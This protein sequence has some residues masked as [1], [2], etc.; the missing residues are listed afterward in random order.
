MGLIYKIT[1]PDGKS[2]I[3]QT[4]MSF[5]QRI[6]YHK[7]PSSGCVY[8]SNAI[9]KHGDEMI[10][11]IIEEDIPRENLDDREIFWINRLNTIAPNGYNLTSGGASCKMSED[12]KSKMCDINKLRKIERDGYL[13]NIY[14]GKTGLFNP[15]VSY[16]DKNGKPIKLYLSNGGYKIREDAINVLKE[17]TRDTDN[18]IK[19]TPSNKKIGNVRK[20]CSKYQARYKGIHVGTYETEQEAREAIYEVHLK[21]LSAV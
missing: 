20:Q 3:G 13:G 21:S 2:Y 17:Y 11:E 14:I 7:H 9:A 5:K 10:Y 8:I 4:T 1:S 16:R 18:F 15:Y 6:R 19:V 12:T